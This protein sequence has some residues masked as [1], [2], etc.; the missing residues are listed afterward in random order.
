MRIKHICFAGVAFL[1]LTGCAG[2]TGGNVLEVLAGASV[3]SKAPEVTMDVEKG[4]II[5]HSAYDG[6]GA[7]L[8][9]ALAPGGL[10]HGK[11]AVAVQFY[12]D[13]AGDVLNTAD[14][15]DAVG[16]AQGVVDDLAQV[17][18]LIVAGKKLIPSAK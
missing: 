1:A 13:K 11:D 15:A 18:N 2:T 12:Y 9:T 14:A 16:N 3:A 10:L 8:L 7:T 6:F 4:L 17:N 5:V